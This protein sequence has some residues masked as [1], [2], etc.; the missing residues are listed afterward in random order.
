MQAKVK[1]QKLF[2]CLGGATNS[3]AWVQLF[4]DVLEIP[5]ETVEGSEIG[6]LGGA[7][8]CLQAIEHLSLAQAIQTMVT[9][10]EHFVPNSKESLIY[11][12]KY[13]VYQHLLDQLDPVWESVKSLQIL[14]NKKEGEK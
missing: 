10:K 13:E 5:I 9:V 11:T 3:K 6:G 7:I 2:E 4:A 12:K 1:N 14:A 8:A